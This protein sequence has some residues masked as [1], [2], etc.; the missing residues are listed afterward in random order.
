MSERQ[1]YSRVY[2]SIQHD[3]KFDGIREDMRLIGSW[4]T[5]I[6]IADQA[7]PAPAYPPPIVPKS[8]IAAL[9]AAEL[10]DQLSGGRYRVRGL[11]AERGRRAAAA[12]RDPNGT[13]PGPEPDPVARIDETRRDETSTRLAETPRD[14]ADIYWNLTGRYPAGKALDWIDNLASTYGHESTVRA[15]VKAQGADK[16]VS[17]L[18]SRTQDILRAEARKLDIAERESEAARLREK[19][20]TPRA[21]EP[22]R[23]EFRDAIRR[24]YEEGDAA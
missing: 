23:A 1:P 6:V 12:K 19:R 24:Q 18:L 22:W 7:W 15:L 13:Q 11:D 4:L 17:D 5:L 8:A 14:A 9:A 10:I 2:W 20:A 3:E 21:E 16:S